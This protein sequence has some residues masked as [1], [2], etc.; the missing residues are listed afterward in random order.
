MTGAGIRRRIQ[1]PNAMGGV[2]CNTPTLFYLQ[3]LCI[4]RPQSKCTPHALQV[5]TGSHWG[6]VI[7]RSGATISAD[8]MSV[9]TI[10]QECMDVHCWCWEQGHVVQHGVCHC[11]DGCIPGLRSRHLVQQALGA[12]AA[13]ITGV[14]VMYHDPTG[15]TRQA[16]GKASHDS[17]PNKGMQRSN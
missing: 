16:I 10:A 11:R 14:S 4:S 6:S 1:G 15:L 5:S 17:D 2:V 3:R 12:D 8:T 9:H 7:H 13:R